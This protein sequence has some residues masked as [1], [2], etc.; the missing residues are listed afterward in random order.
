[1]E[2]IHKQDEDS[3]KFQIMDGQNTAGQIFYSWLG[4]DRI[5]INH[6]EVEPAYNG[7]GIGKQLVYQVVEFARE[8]Q[9]NVV[10]LCTF[11]KR[12]FEK[13]EEIRDVL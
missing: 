1:M 2:I 8:K 13:S 5:V 3:G 11:A 4:K 7:Q 9:I 6:T 10:P 12:I